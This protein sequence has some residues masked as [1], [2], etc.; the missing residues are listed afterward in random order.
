MPSEG[1]PYPLESQ[2]PHEGHE[3]ALI[4]GLS[5]LLLT[6]SHYLSETPG[7]KSIE[8]LLRFFQ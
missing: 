2:L 6:P 8:E 4:F 3:V 1:V 7:I 5:G